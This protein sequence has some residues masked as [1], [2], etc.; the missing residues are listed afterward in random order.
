MIVVTDVFPDKESCEQIAI[1]C[2]EMSVL[3]VLIGSIF[4]VWNYPATLIVHP[5]VY[6]SI[7]PLH[8]LW[9]NTLW[10]LQVWWTFIFREILIII[11]PT[12]RHCWWMYTAKTLLKSSPSAETRQSLKILHVTPSQF[13]ICIVRD[14]SI[15]L[16]NLDTGRRLEIN[17]W[18]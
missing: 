11:V 10:C 2:N 13:T 12:T 1:I 18:Q 8:Y 14:V 4:P 5:S 3:F 17:I 9:V 15:C 16:A 7:H 6:T